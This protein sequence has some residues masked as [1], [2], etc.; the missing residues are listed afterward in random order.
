MLV[1]LS[2]ILVVLVGGGCVLL[3]AQKEAD[4]GFFSWLMGDDSQVGQIHPCE[5]H[6]HEDFITVGN[7]RKTRRFLQH[8]PES[9]DL[10][11]GA[12]CGSC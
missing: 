7:S 6:F 12:W 11:Q 3:F 5:S 9:S 2:F 1:V 8:R 10:L 4:S